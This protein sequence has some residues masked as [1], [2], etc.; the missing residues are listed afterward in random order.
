MTT[1][2]YT[3]QEIEA[4]MARLRAERTEWLEQHNNGDTNDRFALQSYRDMV[5]HSNYWASLL[6][7]V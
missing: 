1:T 3:R 7:T 4:Q 5:F 6:Q 2:K